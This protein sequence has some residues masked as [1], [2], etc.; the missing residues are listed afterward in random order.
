MRKTTRMCFSLCLPINF[1]AFEILLNKFKRITKH[2]LVTSLL[3]P[4][5]EYGNAF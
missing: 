1:A 2:H 4:R 3:T 5:S